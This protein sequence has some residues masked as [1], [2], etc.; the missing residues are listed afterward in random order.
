MHV[1][2][3]AVAVAGDSAHRLWGSAGG[4]AC[5]GCPPDVRCTKPS[6]SRLAERSAACWLDSAC[7][8]PRAVVWYAAHLPTTAGGHRVNQRAPTWQSC[9][10][11]SGSL[12]MVGAT[13]Q[14]SR[15]AC[16]CTP[17][18]SEPSLQL[19]PPLL[20]LQ[21]ADAKQPNIGGWQP[22]CQQQQAAVASGSR[23]QAW[24]QS[25]TWVGDCCAFCRG[26]NWPWIAPAF[27]MCVVTKSA[28]YAGGGARLMPQVT[29]SL[30]GVVQ[31]SSRQDMHICKR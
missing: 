21:A 2:S 27:V 12:P 18:A 3:C 4:H 7:A 17:A 28:R 23:S 30:Q 5:C 20:R 11:R 19:Q 22:C 6:P 14:H 31:A 24:V 29:S 10:C 16:A 9:C 26:A 25:G 13:K 15:K 8:W 1:V